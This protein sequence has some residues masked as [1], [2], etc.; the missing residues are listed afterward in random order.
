MLRNT[1]IKDIRKHVVNLKAV[2]EANIFSFTESM[3]VNNLSKKVKKFIEEKFA[4][5]LDFIK[6]SAE[7]INKDTLAAAKKATKNNSDPEALPKKYS[8]L[9][10]DNENYKELSEKEDVIFETEVAFG[11]DAPVSLSVEHRSGKDL[12]ELIPKNP[13]VI[14]YRGQPEEVNIARALFELEEA[15]LIKLASKKGKKAA[16]EV[17]EDE[18]D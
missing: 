4:D 12:S 17:E 11:V 1:K 9:M 15:G 8:K 6:A 2:A 10:S 5:D 16:A 13:I 7:K 3:N 18:E 14:T